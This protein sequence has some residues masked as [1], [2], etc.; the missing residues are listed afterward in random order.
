[1]SWG[2]KDENGIL[3]FPPTVPCHPSSYLNLGASP[4]KLCC[5]V[6]NSWVGSSAGVVG[7]ENRLRY[8]WMCTRKRQSFRDWKSVAFPHRRCLELSGIVEDKQC[9][10]MICSLLCSH[11]KQVFLFLAAFRWVC[12]LVLRSPLDAAFFL[13]HIRFSHIFPYELGSSEYSTTATK[14][15]HNAIRACGKGGI[16]QLIDNSETN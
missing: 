13:S 5:N 15:H 9:N 3:T 7:G 4:R 14:Q 11:R 6:V 2:T 1:M 12:A 10:H 16:I 8:W